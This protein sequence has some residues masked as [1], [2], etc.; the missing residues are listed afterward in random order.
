MRIYKDYIL[1]KVT[2]IDW[3]IYD[4]EGNWE[5][6]LNGTQPDSPYKNISETL[7]E[8]KARIDALEA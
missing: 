4:Q 2:R 6:Q 8:A 7:K 1:K 5:G 3:V